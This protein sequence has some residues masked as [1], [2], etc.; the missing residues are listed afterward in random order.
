[1]FADFANGLFH[2][3]PA[4]NVVDYMSKV[5][6]TINPATDVFTAEEIAD[7]NLDGQI[8]ILDI[9]ELVNVILGS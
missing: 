8:N 4:S 3:L 2:N 9:I 1:M 6:K 7:L 5:V